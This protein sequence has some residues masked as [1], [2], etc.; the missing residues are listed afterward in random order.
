MSGELQPE[1]RRLRVDAVAA[2]H[3][4]RV[5]VLESAPL[6]PREQ[7]IQIRQ[8]N[9]RG[10]FQLHR[11]ASVEH[12]TRRHA[13]VHEACLGA[14]MLGEVSQE[15]DHVMAGLALDLVDLVD[16]ERAALPYRTR[17]ALRNNPERRLRI[18][19]MRF[20]LKPN[21]VAVLRRPDPR[22]LGPAIA[23]DHPSQP[24]DRSAASMWGGTGAV[25]P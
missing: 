15:R 3:G 8:Q 22:H 20:D 17:S 7:R 6:Q 21:P 18:A 9:V 2:P 13:L 14:D 25:T 10:L 16:L 5:F 12:I 19:G 11:K 1:R 24:N 4:W 23:R